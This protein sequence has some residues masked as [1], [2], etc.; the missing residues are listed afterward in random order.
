MGHANI[1]TTLRYLHH[2]PRH[3]AAAAFTRVRSPRE[4][5]QRNRV[6]NRVPNGGVRSCR[7]VTPEAAGSSPV[8]PVIYAHVLRFASGRARRGAMPTGLVE[9]AGVASIQ[10]M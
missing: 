3:D 8:A 4:G 5:G 9:I 1:Q 6:P 2:G 7:P 10:Q